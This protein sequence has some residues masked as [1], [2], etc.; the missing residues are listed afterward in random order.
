MAQKRSKA[1]WKDVQR[2]PIP[3]ITVQPIG[4]TGDDLLHWTGSMMG[5]EGS[6]YQGGIFNFDIL[7]PRDYPFSPPLCRFTTKLFHPNISPEAYH[8]VLCPEEGGD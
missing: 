8:P 5:P 6:P 3:G 7:L 2:N 1:D 4:E